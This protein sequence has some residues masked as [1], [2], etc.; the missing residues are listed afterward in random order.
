MQRPDD[1]HDDYAFLKERSKEKRARNRAHSAERLD[2]V[3]IKYESKNAG[4]HLIVY[5]QQDVYDFW[6]GTGKFKRRGSS[7]YGRGVGNLIGQIN[8]RRE[9]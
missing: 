3:G 4:A 8:D 5:S 7:K 2:R 6:P 9:G 1:S